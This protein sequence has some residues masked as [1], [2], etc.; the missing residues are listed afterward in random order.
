[1]IFLGTGCYAGAVSTVSTTEPILVEQQSLPK[2]M[3]TS[4]DGSVIAFSVIIDGHWAPEQVEQILGAIDDWKAVLGPQVI[5]PM[6]YGDC[7][8]EATG[9]ITG[10]D[11]YSMDAMYGEELPVGMHAEGFSAENGAIV[12]EK[13]L[14]DKWHHGDLR[15]LTFHELG[16][17]LG[18]D[19]SDGGA[20]TQGDDAFGRTVTQA[21]LDRLSAAG[22]L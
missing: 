3:E 14:G 12:M 13:T 9:C 1:L 10:T 18:L 16:H 2:A 15:T 19:H 21:S 20:M 17:R 11:Q 8:V 4:D 7:T 22:L 5:F 6:S